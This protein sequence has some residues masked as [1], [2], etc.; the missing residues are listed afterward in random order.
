MGTNKNTIVARGKKTEFIMKNKSRKL[1][2]KYIV[3]ECL[4]ISKRNE[5]KCDFLF[6]I[7]EEKIAYFIECKGSDVLKAVKQIDSTV[8]ILR[9]SFTDYILKG[10]IIS[11]KVYSPDIRTSQYIKLREKLNGNLETKNIT[12][13]E[14]I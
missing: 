10:R 2:W 8:S 13:T 12:L 14:T 3:D 7:R 9:L 11:T 6:D 5:E 1:V 4:L